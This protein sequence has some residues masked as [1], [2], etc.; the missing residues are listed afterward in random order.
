MENK[1]YDYLV[2]GS[3]AAGLYFYIFLFWPLNA[4]K[5]F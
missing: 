2:I 4:A 1:V 5:S 3:G